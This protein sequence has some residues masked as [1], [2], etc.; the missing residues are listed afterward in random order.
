MSHWWSN[1]FAP[2][3]P[4]RTIRKSA[5]SVKAVGTLFRLEDRIAPAVNVSVLSSFTGLNI[6]DTAGYVPPD[7]CGA[8]GTS[9]YVETVNQDIKIFNKSNGSA[10]AKTDLGTFFF[11]TG[12]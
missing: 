3:R 8:A 4:T 12:G 9:Q 5:R 7:T 2:N 11:T 6:N 10:L 1:L